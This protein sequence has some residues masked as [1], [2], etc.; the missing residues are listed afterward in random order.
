MFKTCQKHHLDKIVGPPSWAVPH[1]LLVD[2]PLWSDLQRQVRKSDVHP[3]E[4]HLIN[5]Q[6]KKDRISTLKILR[7]TLW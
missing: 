6:E 2:D 4:S 1:V 7:I 3:S 5:G